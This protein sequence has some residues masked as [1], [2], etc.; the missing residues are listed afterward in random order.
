MDGGQ[1]T[2][3]LA[4][5]ELERRIVYETA[6]VV[7]VDKPAGLPSTG[8]SLTDQGSLQRALIERHG[9]MT[10][11]VHQLDADT[12]GLNVFVRQRRLVHLWHRRLSFPVGE[13]IYLAVVHGELREDRIVDAPIGFVRTEPVRELGV[14]PTGRAARTL[15]SVLDRVA[16]YS[17]LQVRIETGRTHQ[18]RIHAASIGHSLVGE[19]WYRD[20]PCERH[21]RQALHAWQLRFH[22]GGE[23]ARL[24]CAVPG[25][26]R[27]L[28]ASLGLVL[29]VSGP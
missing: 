17:L 12:S 6:D 1:L 11:A 15:F 23:P 10:W 29:P 22:D 25:D 8:R 20:T 5:A 24:E 26:L 13:K 27:A 21:H 14:T 19:F 9:S 4:P 18:I 2:A 7:V 3:T 28:I 16:G